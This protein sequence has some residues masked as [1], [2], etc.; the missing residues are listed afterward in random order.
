MR[1]QV[2]RELAEDVRER[3]WDR[4]GRVAEPDVHLAVA[5]KDVAGGE[6]VDAGQWLRVEQKQAGGRGGRVRLLFWCQEPAQ[7]LEP[8]AVGEDGPVAGLELHG[9]DIRLHTWGTAGELSHSAAGSRHVYAVIG[10][11]RSGPRL[12]DVFIIWFT[13][14]RCG[15]FASAALSGCRP[16]GG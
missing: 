8:S 3:S 1:L 7:E 2:A 11:R 9:R 15:S 13:C 14:V 12:S 10:R 16:P 5:V 6:P 4:C